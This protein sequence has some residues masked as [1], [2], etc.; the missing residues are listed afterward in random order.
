MQHAE[1][2]NDVLELIDHFPYPRRVL[3]FHFSK[4]L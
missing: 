3:G 2:V 4:T 1:L